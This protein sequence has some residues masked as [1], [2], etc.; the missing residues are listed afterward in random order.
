MHNLKKNVSSFIFIDNKNEDENSIYCW[1]SFT[2]N[3]L[4]NIS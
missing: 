2:Y 3:L 4:A 1:K